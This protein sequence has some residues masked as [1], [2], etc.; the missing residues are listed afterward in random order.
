MAFKIP[1]CRL[2]LCDSLPT[3]LS[4]YPPVIAYGH[5]LWSHPTLAGQDGE[6]ELYIHSSVQTE[7]GLT[8]SHPRAAS[9][10]PQSGP[11][12]QREKP[13]GFIFKRQDLLTSDQDELL[14]TACPHSIGGCA[15]ESSVDQPIHRMD[16]QLGTLDD[17][18][19]RE[20]ARGP[21][22]AG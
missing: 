2:P 3:L 19:G 17:C 21:K 13:Q 18:G 22:G 7:A 20:D 6:A 5:S 11:K 8:P 15:D 9:V 10:T 14:S 1:Q 12:P 4:G 16:K